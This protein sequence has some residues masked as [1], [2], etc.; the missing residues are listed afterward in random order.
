M[1]DLMCMKW[2]HKECSNEHQNG[3]RIDCGLFVEEVS[4]NSL[5]GQL[6]SLEGL[7]HHQDKGDH[8]Q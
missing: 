2:S 3:Q 4:N 8:G 5:G 6:N 1:N 7:Q